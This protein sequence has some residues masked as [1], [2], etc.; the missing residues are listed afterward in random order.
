MQGISTPN[1]NDAKNRMLEEYLARPNPLAEVQVPQQPPPRVVVPPPKYV[2]PPLPQVSLL[3]LPVSPKVPERNA[4]R[5]SDDTTLVLYGKSENNLLVFYSLGRKNLLNSGR[6]VES[7]LFPIGSKIEL[8]SGVF[9]IVLPGDY[10]LDGKK[11]NITHMKSDCSKESRS[12]EITVNDASVSIGG[13]GSYRVTYNRR[14]KHHRGTKR[15][16][17]KR[18]TRRR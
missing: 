11:V 6:F 8:T 1:G 9:P 18:S 13:R 12:C 2:E 16:R 4:K 10:A 3:R 17:T 15:R 5:Y 7:A 14:I